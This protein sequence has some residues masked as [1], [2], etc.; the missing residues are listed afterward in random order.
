MESVFASRWENV[1]ISYS[2][3]LSSSLDGIYTFNQLPQNDV[4]VTASM[5]LR[6]WTA[7]AIAGANY[8]GFNYGAGN[9]GQAGSTPGPTWPTASILIFTGS[10]AFPNTPP[11]ITS[12]PF[13]TSM[14]RS[15]TIHTTPLPVTMSFLIPSQSINFKDCL[16]VG[17]KVESGSYNSASVEQ[18]LI[19]S[20]YELKF[21][22]PTQSEA[23]RW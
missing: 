22:T 23:R 4:Q 21:F 11:A 12:T 15:A 1:Y 8:G 9:Y 7:E 18:S 3:S 19:V 17:L 6:A 13:T 20:E 10:S 2:S 14:F 16:S 5:L